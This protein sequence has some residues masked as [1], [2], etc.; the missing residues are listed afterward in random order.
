M[1]RIIPVI[2]LG[3][4]APCALADDAPTEEQ[5]KKHPC[6]YD[7]RYRAFDFWIGEWDVSNAAGK[8][9]GRNTIRA[10]AD[11]CMLFERWNGAGGSVGSSINFIDPDTKR[12]RQIWVDG[13][14]GLIEIE[15]A[16]S[17]GAM[18]LVGTHTYR[19]GRKLPFRG[20]WTPLPDGRVRQH[21]EE[22][23]DE[24]ET[25]PTWFDGYYTRRGD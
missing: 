8:Q 6:Q 23:S 17:D 12:W 1:H 13:S 7:E 16:V 9:V 2:L 20:T 24:G 15:G 21:F 5:L 19:D 18:R 11:S 4:L 22:S 10:D 25:W 14:G 3:L